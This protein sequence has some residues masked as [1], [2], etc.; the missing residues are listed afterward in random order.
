MSQYRLLSVISTDITK[1]NIGKAISNTEK[2]ERLKDRA[3]EIK[4][5]GGYQQLP[6]GVNKSL[7]AT[8]ANHQG[9][10]LTHLL[11]TYNEA[12]NSGDIYEVDFLY[13]QFT[14]QLRI[15]EL[16]I[17]KFQVQIIVQH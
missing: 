9:N 13:D 3:D 8:E 11:A 5:A 17:D 2:L 4:D 12:I 14:K 15:T 10:L 7:R 1:G 16:K 6:S